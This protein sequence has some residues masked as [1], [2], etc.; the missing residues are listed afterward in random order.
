MYI[1]V[2]IVTIKLIVK[3]PTISEKIINYKLF[4]KIAKI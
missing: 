2:D 4:L 1:Q 3:P